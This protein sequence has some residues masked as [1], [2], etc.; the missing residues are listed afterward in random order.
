MTVDS[1]TDAI[2]FT[3]GSCI[4]SGGLCPGGYAALILMG[5]SEMVI[6]GRSLATTNTAMEL[7]GVIS[8][9]EALPP[10]IPA[11]IYTDSQYVVTGATERLPWWRS[12]RWRIVK[13]GK[14][15]NKDLWQRLSLLMDDHPISWRWIKGHAGNAR[16]EQ[17]HQW[18]Y[19]EAQKAAAAKDSHRSNTPFQG[20]EAI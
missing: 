6:R 16:N 13:G 18:A 4:G 14:L 1:R 12:R 11:T 5:S 20:V 7:H 19:M 17:V 10:L 8:A 9:L 2:I 15:A 3:D